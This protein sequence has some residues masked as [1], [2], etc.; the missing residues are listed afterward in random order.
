[1]APDGDFLGLEVGGKSP[2]TRPPH[3]KHQFEQPRPCDREIQR[4]IEVPDDQ[5]E[6]P[7]LLVGLA[8]ELYEYVEARVDNHIE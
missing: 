5:L 2:R 3:H 6:R 8:D 1:M 7:A 4:G